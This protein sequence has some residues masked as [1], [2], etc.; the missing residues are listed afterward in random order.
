MGHE[1]VRSQGDQD[2]IRTSPP[3]NMILATIAHRSDVSRD[4]FKTAL[5]P[6]MRTL[7]QHRNA[8][9]NEQVTHRGTQV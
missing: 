3:K 9:S 5:L 1:K 6:S 2:H 8:G 4:R 7:Q